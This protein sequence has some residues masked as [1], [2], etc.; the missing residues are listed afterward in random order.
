ME[1]QGT[2]KIAEPCHENWNQMTPESQGRFCA[3]CQRCVVDFTKKTPVEMKAIYE[4]ENGNVCGRVR[5]S[6]IMKSRPTVRSARPKLRFGALKS[7]QMFALAL[8]AAFSVLLHTEAKAQGREIMGKMA[9]V[10]EVTQQAEVYGRV[11]DEHNHP[12]EGATVVAYHN[13]D[14]VGQAVTN[15]H[16]MYSIQHVTATNIQLH[17][18]RN[19]LYGTSKEFKLAFGKPNRMDITLEEEIL[20]GDIL[21][22]PEET[23]LPPIEE[24][25]P[26]SSVT[27]P[28]TITE[29]PD[30]AIARA[31]SPDEEIIL[32]GFELKAFPNPTTD[33]VTL[34]IERAGT[35]HL[36]VQ[37]V[38]IDGKVVYDG[39]W[40][41]F[42]DAR[43][44][45]DMAALPSGIY[46]LQLQVGEQ[47][48]RRQVIKI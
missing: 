10:P 48:V 13:G 47:S 23:E 4:Q 15:A 24:Q 32:A 22:E 29:T 9:Y 41:R 43:K 46:I 26:E 6:Q 14:V 33:Q 21:Y 34:V 12:V 37:L 5:V 2:F 7:I 8:V 38:D 30:A 42:L 18:S 45:I 36:G 17:G 16:G 1:N 20:L 28:E 27:T 19:F 25:Q 3:S 40:L 31:V 39:V 35:E 11:T 44:T